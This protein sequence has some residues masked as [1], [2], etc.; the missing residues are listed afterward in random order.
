MGRE[1]DDD[2]VKTRDI[3]FR[4]GRDDNDL[5]E[6]RDIGFRVGRDDNDLRETRGSG[7]WIGEGRRR[8]GAHE[9]NRISGG[10]GGR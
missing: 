3:G 1:K 8:F 2:F 10:E 6:T 4:V 5:R 7:F 9:K